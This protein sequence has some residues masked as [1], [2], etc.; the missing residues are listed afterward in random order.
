MN[1]EITIPGVP[2]AKQRPKFARQGSFVRSYTPEL[3]LNYENLVKVSWCEKTGNMKFTGALDAEVRLVFPIPKSVSK[4][5]H[6]EMA[7]GSFPH[8][9]KP[10][11][12]NCLKSIFDGLNG[13]AYEDDSQIVSV[14]A[15]KSYGETPHAWVKLTERT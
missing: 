11:I 1:A 2:Q 8:T 14:T 4:K 15:T 13:I 3:T 5:K 7:A 6:A 12:D 10:D 9:K